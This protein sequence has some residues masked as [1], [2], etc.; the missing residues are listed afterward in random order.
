MR[1]AIGNSASDP[2]FVSQVSTNGAAGPGGSASDPYNTQTAP[3]TA[4]TDRSGNTSGTA[5]TSTTLAAANAN[6]RGLNIQN[7]SA[8]PIGINEIGGAAAIGTPGTYT[9][10]AGGTINV[11]TNRA[12]TVVSAT[13]TQ[14]YTATE[15]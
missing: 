10:P 2:L 9:V 13:A 4:G 11:R 15:F 5:N 1:S 8:N 6:R 3:L 14:P 7:I 12:V